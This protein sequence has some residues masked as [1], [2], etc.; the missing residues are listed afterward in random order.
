MTVLILVQLVGPGKDTAVHDSELL[1]VM[2]A[3]VRLRMVHALV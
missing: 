1:T 2:R 3:L